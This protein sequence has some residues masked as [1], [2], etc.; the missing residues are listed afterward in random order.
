MSGNKELNQLDGEEIILKVK[1]MPESWGKMIWFTILFTG[2]TFSM[3]LINFL[4]AYPPIVG[5]IA[6]VVLIVFCTIIYASLQSY[7]TTLRNNRSTIYF[8]K[9]KM[10]IIRGE[11][12]LSK[13][14]KRLEFLLKQIDHFVEIDEG[15]WIFMK[16]KNGIPYYSGKEIE[17][18]DLAITRNKLIPLY[19]TED[20]KMKEKIKNILIRLIPATSH[21][22]L[23]KIVI[24]TNK[25][26]NII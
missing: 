11:G 9:T 18:K 25:I 2:G 14:I 21:P 26:E 19:G 4:I 8:T 16:R 15:I 3:M 10:I 20:L 6:V 1:P 22:N 5:P 7:D 23:S 12:F 24:S 17:M 13:K